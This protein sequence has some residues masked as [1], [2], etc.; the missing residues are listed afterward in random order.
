MATEAEAAREARAKVV[1]AEGKP[2]LLF[3]FLFN[4]P[5]K[6]PI[7]RRTEGLGSAQTGRGHSIPEPLRPAAKISSNSDAHCRR[8]ELDH[9][10]P[11]T[12]RAHESL[13]SHAAC[14]PIHLLVA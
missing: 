8:E 10:F 14:R 1:A 3:L 12:C 7:L 11:H 5:L 4:S 9:H 13:A 2:H 6:F